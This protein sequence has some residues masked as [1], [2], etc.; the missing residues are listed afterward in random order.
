MLNQPTLEKLQE[1]KFTAMAE[2]W[3]EQQKDTQMSGLAFD[4]R[5]G[6]L[7]DVEWLSRKNRSLERNRGGSWTRR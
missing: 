5:F 6:L 7:V 3:V 2:A 1:L 4:E